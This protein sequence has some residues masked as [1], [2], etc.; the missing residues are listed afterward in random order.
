MKKIIIAVAVLVLLAGIS[1]GSLALVKSKSEKENQQKIDTL[2]D[3]VLFDID[4]ESVSRINI[5]YPDNSTYTAELNGDEWLMTSSSTGENFALNQ[6]VFQQICTYIANLTADKNYGEADEA[7]KAKYGLAEP[8]TVTVSANGTDYTLYIG[9]KSPTGD[10][11]YTY[12]D[13]K[14]NI[15]AVAATDAE[16]IITTHLSLKDNKLVPYGDNE[17]TGLTVKKNGDIVYELNLNP[18]SKLWELPDEYAM[19]TVNQTRPSNIVTTITRLTA[20]EMLEESPDDFTK[21]GFDEPTAEFI[22]K[23]SD[24]TE[25]TFFLSNYG[26]DT[27][28]YTYVYLDDLKQAE[29]YY[30]A[31]LSFIN[32][33]VFDL[34]MQTV[35]NANMY[36]VSDVE[37]TCDELS[38]KFT[39]NQDTGIVE[40]RGSEIDLNNAELK[41]F[42]E[43]F[44]NIFSYTVITDIDVESEP[45]FKDPV[46][47]VKYTKTDGSVSSVDLVPNGEGS[48]CFVFSDG[49]YT[50]TIT[51]SSLILGT[52]SLLTAYDNLCR[53]AGIQANN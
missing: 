32:Y 20:V 14:N 24:G 6:S 30:T 52:N 10:Y 34:I 25:K 26:E 2:S 51:D 12:T 47:S 23:S 39:I 53:Q 48:N 50:G 19:L 33:T 44:Y 1:I 27:S 16:A 29:T 7:N 40:C 41:S 21:Y 22:V 46:F 18:D 36:A 28:T 11:Y 8:Y 37:I 4:S 13:T 43:N 17:I 45:E 31:D 42:F 35:E 3:N 9:D 49:E 15:Y 5:T 38:D